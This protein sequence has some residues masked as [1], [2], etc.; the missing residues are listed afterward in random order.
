MPVT[1]QATQVGAKRGRRQR[2]MAEARV[3]KKSLGQ[4]LNASSGDNHPMP[5]RYMSVQPLDCGG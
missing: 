1:D 2:N 3:P 5:L 4:R